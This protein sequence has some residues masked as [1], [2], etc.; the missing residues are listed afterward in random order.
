MCYSHFP[1]A[2]IIFSLFTRHESGPIYI[3]I[4]MFF[5]SILYACLLL[6]LALVLSLP[7]RSLI[8]VRHSVYRPIFCFLLFVASTLFCISYRL[9]VYTSEHVS[10]ARISLD[11]S[12]V[13]KKRGAL[14]LSAVK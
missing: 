6:F 11:T 3:E 7:I 4:Y 12:T 2:F 10:I 5:I 1:F 8:Y 14:L 13:K 9:L